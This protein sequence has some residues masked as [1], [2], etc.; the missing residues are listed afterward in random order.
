MA[1]SPR[2]RTSCDLSGLHPH[3]RRFIEHSLRFAPRS[4]SSLTV[5][6]KVRGRVICFR[7]RALAG[8]STR[9]CAAFAM[10]MENPFWSVLFAASLSSLHDVAVPGP[11]TAAR[12]GA[13]GMARDVCSARCSTSTDRTISGHGDKCAGSC[14]G[15]SLTASRSRS[16]EGTGWKTVVTDVEPGTA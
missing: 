8:A 16:K 5:R 12:H 13:A 4:R 9:V 10:P 2:T 14:T 15:Q 7:T 1:I 6:A 3:K 11:M